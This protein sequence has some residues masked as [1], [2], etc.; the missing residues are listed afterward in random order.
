MATRCSRRQATTALR[1]HAAACSA[2]PPLHS[3]IL[4]GAIS[5]GRLCFPSGRSA[6]GKGPWGLWGCSAGLPNLAAEG[7]H[8]SH[9]TR[10]PIGVATQHWWLLGQAIPSM[11]TVGSR[12]PA[13]VDGLG[14][15]VDPQRKAAGAPDGVTLV[16]RPPGGAEALGASLF[17]RRQE[18]Q[19]ITLRLGNACS[20]VARLSV[21]SAQSFHGATPW[22]GIGPGPDGA[23]GGSPV[24][25]AGGS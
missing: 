17:G 2:L 13:A 20:F 16:A 24:R 11:E 9:A 1:V 21:L 3:A 8:V 22:R 10:K 25:P 6:I 14:T 18:S 7:A 23:R 4:Q 5:N 15:G 19:T 12:G